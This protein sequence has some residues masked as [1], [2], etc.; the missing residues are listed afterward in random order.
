MALIDLVI[1][2]FIICPF[3]NFFSYLGSVFFIRLFGGKVKGIIGN[4]KT[5][6]RLRNIEVRS[7]YFYGYEY[8][9][10]NL[11]YKSVF[12]KVLIQLGGIIFKVLLLGILLFLLNM[13]IIFMERYT[14]YLMIVI[15]INFLIN[16]PSQHIFIKYL[17]L[18]EES[19]KIS[20]DLKNNLKSVESFISKV[21]KELIRQE[22]T[23]SRTEYN[24]FKRMYLVYAIN[25]ARILSSIGDFE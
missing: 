21:D 6:F 24:S 11:K 17:Q 2:I 10:E 1:I 5:V 9:F 14:C 4:G 20:S 8:Y 7:R 25:K 18:D 15:V 12:N 19:K 22:N 3:V 16:I 23:I 13:E